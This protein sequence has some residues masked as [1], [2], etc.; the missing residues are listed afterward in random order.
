MTPTLFW[1]Y[2]LLFILLFP[3]YIFGQVAPKTRLF[4]EGLVSGSFM[5]GRSIHVIESP[6]SVYFNSNWNKG[7]VEF[8]NGRQQD[9]VYIRY[10]IASSTVDIRNENEIIAHPAR[11]IKS[12]SWYDFV[13][14]DS[15][16]FVSLEDSS[17]PSS[18]NLYQVISTGK[19]NM[20]LARTRIS[21][22]QANYLP[23]LDLGSPEK[24]VI[25]HKEFFIYDGHKVFPI[26]KKLEKNLSAFQPFEKEVYLFARAYRFKCKREEDL[27]SMIMYFNRLMLRNAEE[28]QEILNAS[29]PK[30]IRTLQ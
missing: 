27:K 16:K 26:H 28:I 23:A 24:K 10:D 15:V 9:N 1:R 7:H 21:I 2:I 12:F 30:A 8:Q 14:A 11:F 18:E 17:F 19:P 29:N 22:Q 6:S 3:L 5:D 4:E 13:I 25:R 20:L